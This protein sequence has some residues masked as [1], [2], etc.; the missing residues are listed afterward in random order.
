MSNILNSD[1]SRK[2][3]FNCREKSHCK[4]G[5]R[6]LTSVSTMI[7]I[8]DGA[9]RHEKSSSF[10]LQIG[11]DRLQTNLRPSQSFDLLSA[12][13]GRCSFVSNRNPLPDK[14]ADY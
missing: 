8:Y 11:T 13:S 12:V 1:A 14:L 2:D 9:T 4:T 6:F 5:T 10:T 7:R 3:Q